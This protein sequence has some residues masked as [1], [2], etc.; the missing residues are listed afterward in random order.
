VPLTFAFMVGTLPLTA[1]KR[2]RT[3]VKLAAFG[4]AAN[5]ALNLVFVPRLGAVGSALATLLVSVGL[6]A[7]LGA[8]SAPWLRGLP[9]RR[10]SAIAGATAIMSAAAWGAH[11]LAG[12]WAA[13]GVAIPTYAAA[14]VALRAVSREE[15]RLVRSRRGAEEPPREPLPAAVAP[16]AT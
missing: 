9:I 10:L 1:G 4:L 12:M 15:L 8:A 5:V 2:E 11:R 3:L 7:G 16:P 13:I 14:L 6:C